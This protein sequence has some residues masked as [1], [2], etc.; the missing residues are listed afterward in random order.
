LGAETLSLYTCW[1]E[2]GVAKFETS[3]KRIEV[4][5]CQVFKVEGGKIK[6]FTHYFDMVTLLTQIGALKG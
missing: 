6:S 1:R 3:N 5:A 2:E 4:P